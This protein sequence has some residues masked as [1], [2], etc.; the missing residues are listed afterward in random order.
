[1]LKKVP[2]DALRIGMHIH[3]L[4]GSWMEHPF[5]RNSFKLRYPEDIRRI[6]ESGIHEAWIDTSKGVDV[7]TAGAPVLDKE[8]VEA[9]V[10]RELGVAA[11]AAKVPERVPMHAEL[12]RAAELCANSKAAVVSM[13]NE[14]RMGRAIQGEAAMPLVSAIAESVMRNPG[15]LISIARL[16][17]KD[18]ST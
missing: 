8:A 2:V 6:S 13:F 4:C 1:M 16:K 17:N 18:D 5:W 9:A 10:E 7:A 15:A 14:V 12:A 3:E 11:E